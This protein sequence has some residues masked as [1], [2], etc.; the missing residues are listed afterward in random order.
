[1]EE[2]EIDTTPEAE[3][4]DEQISEEEVDET[5]D[6]EEE[7][8]ESTDEEEEELDEKDLQIKELKEKLAKAE[9]AKRQ[10]KRALNKS[11][12]SDEPSHDLTPKDIYALV[13]AK[14]PQDD[15]DEVVKA[16]KILGKSIPEALKDDTVKTILKTRAEYRETAKATN[17]KAGRRSAKKISDQEI[18]DNANKGIFPEKG[19]EEAE[20]LFMLRRSR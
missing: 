13:D 19:S 12:K 20:R 15:I 11:K 6:S 10:T 8:E 14:V 9:K 5:E 18:L 1:M 2:K 3:L 17:T 4:E 7:E 16:A